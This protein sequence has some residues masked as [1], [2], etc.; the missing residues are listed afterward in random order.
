[1][2]LFEG[3]FD[4][5]PIKVD[6]MD[7]LTKEVDF[8]DGSADKIWLVPDPEYYP[9][10]DNTIFETSIGKKKDS[11]FR[12]S[13]KRF[14]FTSTHLMYTKDSGP[15]PTPRKY[16]GSMELSWSVVSYGSSTEQAVLE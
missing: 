5:V 14:F 3:F 13:N 7:Y 10:K 2:T 1:M 16:R 6:T 4:Y 12:I 11:L 9:S 8:S 15:T